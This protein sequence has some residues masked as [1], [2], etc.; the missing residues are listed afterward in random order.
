MDEGDRNERLADL[1]REVS[2]LRARVRVLESR[3]AEGGTLISNT[4]GQTKVARLSED[5][6]SLEVE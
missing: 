5:G 1:E 2:E 3:L 4:K 6:E